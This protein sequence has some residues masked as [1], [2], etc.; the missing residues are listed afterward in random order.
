MSTWRRCVKASLHTD[1]ALCSRLLPDITE[2]LLTSAGE[3]VYFQTHL[4]FI[5]WEKSPHSSLTPTLIPALDAF[6]HPSAPRWILV[7]WHQMMWSWHITGFF[8]LYV[9]QSL[10]QTVWVHVPKDCFLC[11]VFL[12]LCRLNSDWSWPPAPA[13]PV[14]PSEPTGSDSLQSAEFLQTWCIDEVLF[15]II[16]ISQFRSPCSD[17]LYIWVFTSLHLCLWT[18]EPVNHDTITCYQWTCLPVE[19]SKQVFSSSPNSKE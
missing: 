5:S 14:G 6:P 18:T 9:S 15:V 8:W 1:L 16:I 3:L 10:R 12:F 17:P 19:G 7:S 2:L 4:Y 13:A 11:S